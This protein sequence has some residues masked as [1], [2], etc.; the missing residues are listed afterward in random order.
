MEYYFRFYM[1]M[2][3]T[4]TEKKSVNEQNYFKK[5]VIRTVCPMSLE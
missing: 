4:D 2:K 5:F 1:K 3:D